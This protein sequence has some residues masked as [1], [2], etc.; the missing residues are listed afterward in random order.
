MGA[1]EVEGQVIYDELMA[2]ADQI[3]PFMDRVGYVFLACCALALGISALQ[4]W[5]IQPKSQALPTGG[6]ATSSGFNIGAAL[7]TAALIAIYAGLG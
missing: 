1:A 3:L 5:K 2:V 4:G 7:V 6:F